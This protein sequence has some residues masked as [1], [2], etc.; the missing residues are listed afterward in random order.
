[1][2]SILNFMYNG[3]VNVNQEDLQN[4][5]AAAEELKIKGLSQVRK[6]CTKKKCNLIFLI[7]LFSYLYKKGYKTKTYFVWFPTSVQDFF[8]I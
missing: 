2:V 3:E 4:F 6:Y 5:L 1:M 8:V 7:F